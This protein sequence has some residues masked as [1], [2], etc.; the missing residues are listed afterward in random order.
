MRPISTPNE[1]VRSS[2]TNN[3]GP[4]FAGFMDLLVTTNR[5]HAARRASELSDAVASFSGEGTTPDLAAAA[6]GVLRQAALAWDNGAPAEGAAPGR[7]RPPPAEGP[8]DQARL[9]VNAAG[10]RTGDSHR[11]RAGRAPRTH[12]TSRDS[13]R[14]P[15]ATR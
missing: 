12:P 8:M 7:A 13:A 15:T 6:V 4:E 9:A 11:R 14:Q 3:L 2:L 10:G 1:I 5:V